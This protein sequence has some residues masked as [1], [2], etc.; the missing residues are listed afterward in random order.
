MKEVEEIPNN[1]VAV[2]SAHGVSEKVEKDAENLNVIDATCPLVKKVHNQAKHLS[3]TNREI[4][5]IGHAGHPEVEGTIGRVINKKIHLIQNIEDIN[6]LPF[7]CDTPV[8][9]ITQT[10]LSIDDTTEI[11]MAL[12][13]RFTDTV[14]PA[15]SDICYA[16][17][18]RQLSVQELAKTVEA[19]YVIGA[20]NSS[21]SVRLVETAKL[22]G[23]PHA[24]LV[25]NIDDF[26]FQSLKNY[27]N[28]GLTASASAPE[29]LIKKF[30]QKLE[31]NYSI[32]INDQ[33]IPENVKFKVP[34]F[35][36]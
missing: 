12:K 11:I 15:S 13:N 22:F 24:L 17:S 8:S 23:S 6:S 20:N 19:F 7:T 31:E 10:T 1:A 21:N 35:L 33:K 34:N 30:V 28:I 5:L 25:E 18:N 36:N 9:Y 32:T 2:F 16:T 29:E 26:D 27:K 3:S 4:V 14:G